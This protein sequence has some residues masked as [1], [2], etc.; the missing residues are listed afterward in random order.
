M[1]WEPVTGGYSRRVTKNGIGYTFTLYR[2]RVEQVW[3][4]Q[5]LDKYKIGRKP[6]TAATRI[7][8]DILRSFGYE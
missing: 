2:G 4:L 1:G 8:D 6:L 3:Y 5:A 7:A